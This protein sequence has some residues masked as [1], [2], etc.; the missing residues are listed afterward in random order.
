MVNFSKIIGFSWDEGNARKNQDK[1]GVTQGE[2]EEMFFNQPLLV[3]GDDKHSQAELRYVALG[4]TNF[5]VLLAVVFTLRQ[6]GTLIRVI[7]ARPMSKKERMYY[8]KID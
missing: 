3:V 1:H 6:E 2:A 4:S 5:D 7:S 8:E